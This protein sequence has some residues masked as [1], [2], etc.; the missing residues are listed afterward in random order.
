MI[1]LLVVDSIFLLC[2]P[3]DFYLMLYI[4]PCTLLSLG[5]CCNPL[6]S[7]ELFFFSWHAVKLL[8][9]SLSF[10]RENLQQLLAKG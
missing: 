3:V 6:I 8:S 5:F 2:V 9:T 4:V 7:M 1:F 10:G